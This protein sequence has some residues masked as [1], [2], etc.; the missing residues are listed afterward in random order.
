M[1]GASAARPITGGFATGPRL[2]RVLVQK[3][4]EGASGIRG[5]LQVLLSL[6]HGVILPMCHFHVAATLGAE[7]LQ[8]GSGHVARV[9]RYGRTYCGIHWYNWYSRVK[10]NPGFFVA[11]CLLIV[12]ASSASIVAVM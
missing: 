2:S 11:R 9:A 5:A 3:G 12:V 7:N 8:G 6:C 1:R 4:G 10:R